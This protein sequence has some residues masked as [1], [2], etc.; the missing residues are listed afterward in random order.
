MAAYRFFP[1]AQK[2]RRRNGKGENQNKTKDLEVTSRR[3]SYQQ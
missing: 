2:I 3:D 1:V